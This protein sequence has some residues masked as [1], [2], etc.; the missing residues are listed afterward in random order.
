[1]IAATLMLFYA[2]HNG[3]VFRR[4]LFWRQ[5]EHF[6]IH[7]YEGLSMIAAY[8]LYLAYLTWRG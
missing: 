7:R 5:R 2:V 6:S 8:V 4:L 3:H 1:M